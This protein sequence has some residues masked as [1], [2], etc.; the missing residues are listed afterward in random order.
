MGKTVIHVDKITKLQEDKYYKV[1]FEEISMTEKT[2]ELLKIFESLSAYSQ[3]RLEQMASLLREGEKNA[4]R[5]IGIKDGTPV[6]RGCP[7][8]QEDLTKHGITEILDSR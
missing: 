2:L 3:D 7:A 6:S 1:T 4:L 5:N 8:P